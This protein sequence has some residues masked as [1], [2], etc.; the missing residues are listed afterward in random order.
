MEM[1]VKYTH[2]LLYCSCVVIDGIPGSDGSVQGVMGSGEVSRESS[3]GQMSDI[4]T[5]VHLLVRV[6]VG[7]ALLGRANVHLVVLEASGLLLDARQHPGAGAQPGELQEK[8]DDEEDVC[9]G[10]VQ[11]GD[12]VRRCCEL[13][14]DGGEDGGDDSSLKSPVEEGLGSVRNSK[15]VVAS[16]R[17]NREG[18][19]GSNKEEGADHSELT[20]DHESR[21]VLPVALEEEVTRLASKEGSST[22]I[23][24]KLGHSEESNLHP[25]EHA[26][27]GHEDEEENDS[28]A[29]GN[30]GVLDRHG[31]IA[32]QKRDKCDGEAES[33]DGE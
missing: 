6:V 25:L 19:E 21:K 23:G 17:L 20:S 27:N 3:S 24:R 29:T 31:G 16:S 1:T 5:D 18:G 32:V 30:A 10:H 4:L 8:G 9:E 28:E 11:E 26:D 2:T 14:A 13:P 12:G 7:H 22:L 15:D 33:K